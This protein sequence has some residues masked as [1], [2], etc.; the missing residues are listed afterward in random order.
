ML[1][2]SSKLGLICVVLML[3]ILYRVR[4]KWPGWSDLPVVKYSVDGKGQFYLGGWFT[5]YGMGTP[6]KFYMILKIE[7]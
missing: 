7:Y 4:S 2:L 1:H 5:K 6:L 3:K